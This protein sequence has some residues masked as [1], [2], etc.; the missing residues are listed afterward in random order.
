MGHC[1]PVPFNIVLV[2]FL[3]LKEWPPN[4]YHSQFRIKCGAPHLGFKWDAMV[5]LFCWNQ[6]ESCPNWGGGGEERGSQV[7]TRNVFSGVLV[8]K[9]KNVI[10][11]TCRASNYK[12]FLLE[13][14]RKKYKKHNLRKK[15]IIESLFGILRHLVGA[16]SHTSFECCCVLTSF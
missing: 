6:S 16:Y 11:I 8:L 3:P 4:H 12:H 15:S 14:Q 10:I 5:P 13:S 1:T 7:T 2:P 9:F